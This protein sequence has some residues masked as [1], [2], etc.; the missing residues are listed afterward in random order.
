MAGT[1]SNQ[2]FY[3]LNA[4]T[5]IRLYITLLADTSLLAETKH[6]AEMCHFVT[7]VI[8]L[9]RKAVVPPVKVCCPITR[10]LALAIRAWS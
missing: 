9:W 10:S 2:N 7:T 8:L 5:V 3:R 1:T 6:L 4:V